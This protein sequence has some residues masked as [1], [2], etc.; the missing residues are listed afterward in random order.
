MRLLRKL[1]RRKLRS[2]LTV[3]GVL[4][5]IMALVVFGS[6]ANKIG[7]LVEG[8]SVYYDDKVVVSTNGGFMGFGGVMSMADAE[9]IA[10]IERVDAAVPS[11][12][13]LL[14]D[15]AAGATMGMPPIIS[16]SVAGADLG[17][18]TFRLGYASGRALRPGDEGRYLTVLGTDL[19][20]QH[21]VGVGD[22]ITMRGAEF[23]VVG[24]LEPTLTAPDNSAMVPLAAAQELFHETLPAFLSAGLEP[25]DIVT[26]VIVY[27]TPGSDE[28]A[29]AETIGASVEGVSTMTGEDFDE[30][31]GAATAILNAMLVGIGVITLIVG[32][33]S[34]VNTM[35]MS[36]AERTREIGIKRAVGASRWRIRREIVCE[37]GLIGL[38]GGLLG[39][40]VGAV[41]VHLGNEAGR[42]S[43]TVLFDL[44]A[45][46]GVTAVLFAVGL[47]ALAGLVPAVHASRLDPVAALRYQ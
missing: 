43:G 1:G 9:A 18:E 42:S 24:V 15:E 16:G 3:T 11:V 20:R 25:S 10:A 23:E 45:W 14:D 6:M 7:S 41:I 29:L 28:V 30:Q 5:G 34:V 13:L 26:S 12:T 35:A 8:G 37:S 38:I 40:A 19:A 4:I 21:E 39:L 33:L 44:T 17:R 31:I 27:P 2:T 22:S 46:T 47:G 32:G 36:V